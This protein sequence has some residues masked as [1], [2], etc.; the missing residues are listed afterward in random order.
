MS[1]CFLHLAPRRQGSFP[2]ELA[3]EPADVEQM[4]DSMHSAVQAALGASE[5]GSSDGGDASSRSIGDTGASTDSW[6]AQARRPA[7]SGLGDC[8]ATRVP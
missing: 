1:A 5:G 8:V 2:A 4:Y 3:L 6:A 7:L